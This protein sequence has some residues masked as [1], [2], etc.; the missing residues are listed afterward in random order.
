MTMSVTSEYETQTHSEQR[1]NRF[2]FYPCFHCRPSRTLKIVLPL[3]LSSLHRQIDDAFFSPL[4]CMFIT[5][6]LVP[7]AKVRVSVLER[8][9][10]RETAAINACMHRYLLFFIG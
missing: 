1:E 3:S 4:F 5:K 6:S 2:Q 9:R 7:N 10:E 8:E